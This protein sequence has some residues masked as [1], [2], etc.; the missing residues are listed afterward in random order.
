LP[1]ECAS[2]LWSDDGAQVLAYLQGRGFSEETLRHWRVGAHLLRGGDGNVAEQ[3][4]ALPVLDAKGEAMNMR[5][6]SVP[7]A[8]LRCGGTSCDRC[9]AGQVKKVYLRCPGAASTLFGVHQ[10]DGDPS[11][12]VVITEGELDVLA[13]WQYGLRANVVTGTAGAGTWLD[14]W[15]D[16][17][18]PYR[19][20]LLAYDADTA[21]E[22]GA[23]KLA[24]KL[25]RERCS[26]VKLPAKDAAD[27][28][29]GCV[30]QRTVHAALDAAVPMVDVKLVRVDAYSDAIEQLVQRPSEMRGLPTG[31]VKLD[32]ALGGWRPGLVVVTGDTAAGKTSWT[33][34]VAREQALRGVPVMLTSFEQ[35]PIGTVQKLLRAQMGGDFSRFNEAQ[36]RA[37]MGELGKQ[38]IHP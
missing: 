4:V 27:C 8:C 5:F 2:A 25:G 26:R 1:D 34:W 31:S 32:E 20:F 13:L 35:R 36:R 23:V 38:P 18:E 15:L 33:T 3:Y 19:S 21:G 11:S 9:K 29:A 16:V 7:G 37:A 28:L 10:L 30:A 22:D 6:R 24:A 12:E 14:E 17:L